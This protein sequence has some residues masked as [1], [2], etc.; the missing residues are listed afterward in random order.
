MIGMFLAGQLDHQLLG[1][2]TVDTCDKNRAELA[3]A[4]KAIVVR[5]LDIGVLIDEDA[6]RI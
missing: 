3:E 5:N 6:C 4:V 2:F 1:I